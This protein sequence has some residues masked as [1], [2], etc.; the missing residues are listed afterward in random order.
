MKILS[1]ALLVVCLLSVFALAVSPSLVSYQG[2]LKDASGNPVADNTYAVTFSLYSVPSGGS[3]IWTEI[4]TVTTVNGLFSTVLGATTPFGPTAFSDSVRY[5]GVK[6]AADP[7]ISPRSRLA[8]VPF[9]LTSNNGWVDSGRVVRLSNDTDYVGIGT[10]TPIHPLHV[11]DPAG[12]V[13]VSRIESSNPGAMVTELAN[14]SANSVWEL[15]VAGSVGIPGWGVQPGDFYSYKQ[16]TTF[17]ALVLSSARNL[18]LGTAL[19][20]ARIEAVTLDTTAGLF[21]AAAASNATKVLRAEYTGSALWDAVAVYGKSAPGPYYGI[22]GSF[23]GGYAGVRGTV[24]QSG[25]DSYYGMRGVAGGSGAGSF[26]GVRGSADAL[27]GRNY[28]VYGSVSGGSAGYGVYGTAVG[29]PATGEVE[30]GVYG[31][32]S[33]DGALGG[34]FYADRMGVLGIGVN[35]GDV[36]R[37]VQGFAQGP[38]INYGIYGSALFGTVNWAGYFSGDVNVS[39]T[40]SKGAGAF[41][42]D[43]PL[44]PENKYL[45]H[46][47]VESPDM[48]NI[49]NGNV[50]TDAS[51]IATI[52]LPEWFEALNQDFRY[53]L[54][55][56][57][58]FAQAIV[59]SKVSNNRFSIRTD[60]PEVEVSWQVTGIRKDAYAEAHR[61]EVEVT[62]SDVERGKYAHPELFGK[63][64]EM[65]V[66]YRP[67]LERIRA[68]MAERV[69][70]EKSPIG[71]K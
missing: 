52:M 1:F 46:S 13:F 43:H 21:L 63:G 9:A 22:G 50:V 4:Q 26:Y 58:E 49:Y 34:Y 45:Q 60:K 69:P 42:I 29:N 71:H 5:L 28:G 15:S 19:P 2:R 53:Q 37:G 24:I 25:A 39:G 35:G 14:S 67:E 32:G 54:T 36:T 18:G 41:R 30:A 61:I 70:L 33:G 16:G 56:I 31:E 40:L 12:G 20:R 55:V 62:K 68:S 23:E 66:D 44:H 47:F 65:G 57:G 6:V 10:S 7:E 51:G 48:M 8:S 64:R 11:V 17:P 59:S 38:T 27:N 3:A